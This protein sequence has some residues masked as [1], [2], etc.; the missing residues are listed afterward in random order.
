[1][2]VIIPSLE[3]QKVEDQ[4]S[5]QRFSILIVFPVV[6]V[7]VKDNSY[8]PKHK[9]VFSLS[10]SEFSLESSNIPFSLLFLKT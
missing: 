1:M 7:H 9:N 5:A 2:I 10:R 3:E 6:R 4:C 8:I